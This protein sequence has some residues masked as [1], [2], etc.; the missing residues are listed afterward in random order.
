[1]SS[2]YAASLALCGG[3]FPCAWIALRAPEP[4]DRLVALEM[5]SALSTL[6]L[7]TLAEAMQRPLFLDLALAQAL[8][9][10]GGGLVY[11]H[12]IERWL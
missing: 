6:A 9:S 7:V 1:M 8:L 10:F 12:F 11:A 2:W 3:L 4:F 5:A